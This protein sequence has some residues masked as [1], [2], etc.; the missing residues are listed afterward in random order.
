MD[1]QISKAR[2]N[3]SPGWDDLRVF[4][5]LARLGTLTAAAGRL[6][7]APSSIAR[8]VEGLERSLNTALFQRSSQGYALTDAGRAILHD[9]EAAESA[10]D[11]L[12]RKSLGLSL[13][14][15]GTVRIALPEN[16]ATEIVL[17]AMSG[18]QARYPD[19]RVE[20]AADVRRADL[21]R[22]EADIAVRLARPKHDNFVAARIGRME[23]C[24]FASRVYLAARPYDAEG[25][26]AGHLR[27]DRGEG[28]DDLPIAVWLAAELP[29]AHSAMTAASLR[30]QF[31]AAHAGLGIAALPRFLGTGLARLGESRL[32][33]D[34]FLVTHRDMRASP[35]VGTA[36]T[37]LR[38]TFH[39]ARH[40]LCL[41]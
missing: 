36:V 27:I 24:L 23:T 38:E 26:G 4:L 30:A 21:T 5:A 14:A 29:L 18:F 3:A 13:E 6:G 31:P 17:P 19:L 12:I 32:S 8:H 1:F 25:R 33:Q 2:E 7:M 11:D 40:R 10:I 28:L 39:Q 16:L 9:A 35:R 20:L 22:R 41:A 37:F 15:A 34:I